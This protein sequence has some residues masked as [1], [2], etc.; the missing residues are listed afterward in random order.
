MTD[1]SEQEG[2]S[3]REGGK[4]GA[5]AALPALEVEL[6]SDREPLRDR[7]PFLFSDGAAWLRSAVGLV[8][9]KQAGSRSRRQGRRTGQGKARR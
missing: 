5:G 4:A 9:T 6:E 8:P 1:E 2:C 7:F 3:A